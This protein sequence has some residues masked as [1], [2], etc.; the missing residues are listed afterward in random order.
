MDFTDYVLTSSDIE[1]RVDQAVDRAIPL[2][3]QA[4]S[5]RSSEY[6]ATW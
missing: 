1:R 4:A 5:V 3:E 6:V 2:I